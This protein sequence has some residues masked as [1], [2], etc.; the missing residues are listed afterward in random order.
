M[1]K[2][3]LMRYTEKNPSIRD[4]IYALDEE[5]QWMELVRDDGKPYLKL[6][7]FLLSEPIHDEDTDPVILKNMTVTSY[8]T[9]IGEKQSTVNKWLRQ[10]YDDIFDLNARCPERFVN[11]GE[12]MCTFHYYSEV[13]KSGFRFNLGLKCIP[14]VG[15]RID[16]FF[17]QAV[18]DSSSLIVVD[19]THRYEHGAMVTEIELGRR[20]YYGSSYRKLLID[21]ALFLG[22]LSF[23]DKYAP[24]Y[25]LDEKLK[26]VFGGRMFEYI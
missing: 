8:S 10:I 24:D 15:D 23:E 9:R 6:I 18:T 17:P 20:Y 5:R 2:L 19:M 3:R 7:D 21:K 26:K 12:Q 25:E 13:D 22:W 11:P 4:I 14:R 1:D 16:F